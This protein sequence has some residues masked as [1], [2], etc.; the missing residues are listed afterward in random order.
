MKPIIRRI[1]R[2]KLNILVYLVILWQW[3]GFGLATPVLA[4]TQDIIVTTSSTS[5]I[6][7]TQEHQSLVKILEVAKDIE[8]EGQEIELKVKLADEPEVLRRKKVVITAYSSTVD[9]TD[10]T[11]CITAN[12]YDLCENGEVNVVAANFL[13]FGTKIRI[14]EYF[15][16]QIFIVQDRM[17]PRFANRVD[18]WMKTRD[19]AIHFGI[20]RLEIEI[21]K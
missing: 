18:V 3:L 21:L 7:N 4:K 12:G 2:K 10:D 19:E 14:P 9:Q 16:D 6:V 15:G 20:Q 5:A 17:H 1:Y 8:T 11:P 13:R